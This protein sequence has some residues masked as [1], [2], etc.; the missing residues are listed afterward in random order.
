MRLTCAVLLLLLIPATYTHA[1]D[2]FPG[3]VQYSV[4][5]SRPFTT[6]AMSEKDKAWSQSLVKNLQYRGRVIHFVRTSLP[7]EADNSTIQ[8]VVYQAMERPGLFYVLRSDAMLE[9][10]HEWPYNPGVGGF[11]LHAPKSRNS[12][13]ALHCC[14]GGVPFLGSH[15]I[16][17]KVTWK[18]GNNS[19]LK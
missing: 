3:T 1:G 12:L 4:D 17:G 16:K 18:G 5:L 2:Y 8:G 13:V 10:N 6:Y 9:L 7:L 15:V 14:N 19:Q 11:S